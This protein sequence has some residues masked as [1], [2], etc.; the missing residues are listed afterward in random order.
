MGS[1]TC[2]FFCWFC[3]TYYSRWERISGMQVS[4]LD[5]PQ[6]RVITSPSP[7]NN[8]CYVEETQMVFNN[9]LYN[10][11]LHLYFQMPISNHWGCMNISAKNIVVY[12]MVMPLTPW[13][14][15]G[16][17]LILVETW[18]YVLVEKPFLQA[19]YKGAYG[20]P[21][22]QAFIKVPMVCQQKGDS[23]QYNSREFCQT[24]CII[25]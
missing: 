21:T 2:V 18:W 25:K 8:S 3:G 10:V 13:R 19:S 22:K 12:T 15:G 23:Y 7:F 5:L 17:H 20:L 4:W 14:L 1:S 24:L 11:Q 16:H 9:K 6:S